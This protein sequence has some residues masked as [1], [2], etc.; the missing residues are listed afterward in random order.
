MCGVGHGCETPVG[1]RI[2]IVRLLGRLVQVV[3][4]GLGGKVGAN[5]ASV[6]RVGRVMPGEI[7]DNVVAG[8]MGLAGQQAQARAAK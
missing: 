3:R 6:D 8:I 5:R 4:V 2:S 7:L 1:R